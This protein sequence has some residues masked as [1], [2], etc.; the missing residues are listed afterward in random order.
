MIQTF[1]QSNQRR[2][3]WINSNIQTFKPTGKVSILQWLCFSFLRSSEIICVRSICYENCLCE[4]YLYEIYM[5]ENYLYDD[6]LYDDYLYEIWLYE[7][8]LYEM[9]QYE[10]YM[11][12]NYQCEN[13]MWE[14]YLYKIASHG[15][16][17]VC[18]DF[19]CRWL[20][21]VWRRENASRTARRVCSLRC[22]PS[23]CTKT[24]SCSWFPAHPPIVSNHEYCVNIIFEATWVR[25]ICMRIICV[26]CICSEIIY[27]RSMCYENYLCEICLLWELSVLDLLV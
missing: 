22:C 8:Y 23:K 6:Y 2:W 15:P 17:R 19:V 21:W 26:R 27:V 9:Y 12:E 24:K 10:N 1:K 5:Y 4:N 11:Y 25:F 7:N 18:S 3:V 14:I 13:Y 16:W 20:P